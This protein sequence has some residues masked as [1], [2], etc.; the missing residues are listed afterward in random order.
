MNIRQLAKRGRRV[1]RGQRSRPGTVKR[2]EDGQFSY[3]SVIEGDRKPDWCTPIA[4]PVWL[5]ADAATEMRDDDALVGYLADSG[6]YAFPWWIMKNHHV[7]NLIIDDKPLLVSFCEACAGAAAYDPVVAGTRYT[8]QVEGL[9]GGI[10]LL[11]DHQHGNLWSPFTGHVVRGPARGTRLERK[12]VMQF[13]WA[14]WK[15]LYPQTLVLDGTGETRDGHGS[16]HPNPESGDVGDT[17]Q[18]TQD[19]KDKRMDQ[20]ALVLGVE[21]GGQSVAFPLD[22]V[23]SQG[24]VINT[25]VGGS[26]IAVVAKPGTWVTVAYKREIGSDVV[27]LAISDEHLVDQTTGRRWDFFGRPVSESDPRLTFVASGL[28]KW[29]AWSTY[30]PQS[31]IFGK[32]P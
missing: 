16:M 6:A 29:R 28:E 3:L 1:L 14:E 5:T 27:D 9:Y 24:G 7:A 12:P 8:F 2:S 32:T 15:S 10:I 20:A 13:T 18:S 19:V 23:Q 4:D 11:I 31:E 25:T 22:L 30:H 21:A 26:P 17:M